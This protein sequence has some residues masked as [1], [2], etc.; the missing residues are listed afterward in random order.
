MRGG[1]G[2]ALV[3]CAATLMGGIL[4]SSWGS[5]ASQHSSL[6]V[7]PARSTFPALTQDMLD[8]STLLVEWAMEIEFTP[9]Q[10][11][12]Q[13][14]FVIDDWKTGKAREIGSTIDAVEAWDKLQAAT[15]AER[16]RL[17]VKVRPDCLLSVQQDAATGDASARWLLDVVAEYRDRPVVPAQGSIAA[18]TPGML[19][20]YADTMEIV[21][22]IRLTPAQRQELKD[23]IVRHWQNRNAKDIEAVTGWLETER[24][25]AAAGL[26]ASQRRA[27][28]MERIHPQLIEQA[29]SEAQTDPEVAWILGIH[30]EMHAPLGAGEPR[31]TR[32]QAEAFLE[33]LFFVASQLEGGAPVT[34]PA[35]MLDAWTTQL[36]TNWDQI[37]AEVKSGMAQLSALSLKIQA[38]WDQTPADV[39]KEIMQSFAQIPQVSEIAGQIRAMRAETQAN[40]ER[41]A[42]MREEGGSRATARAQ[43]VN[44]GQATPSVI[45]AGS[46]DRT[47]E[48]LKAQQELYWQQ[49][50]TQMISNM[51]YQM[52]QTRMMVIYNMGNGYTWERRYR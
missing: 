5:E 22:D 26:T 29:R 47:T 42:R 16:E 19:N 51:M 31:V 21:F 33:V 46:S 18:L 35:E 25:M 34:P 3:F 39:Q 43:T 23:Q 9:E 52:H 10:R 8:K 45:E 14:L 1:Y 48:F 40:A 2:L 11:R 28:A 37:P 12:R 7:L 17:A 13:Q 36:A 44:A 20:R 32:R 41:V 15:A 27:V 30:D 49:Q 38:L 24:Q 6:I 4:T 50:K